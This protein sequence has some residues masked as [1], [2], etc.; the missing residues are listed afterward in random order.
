MC[1]TSLLIDKIIRLTEQFTIPTQ[2]FNNEASSVSHARH[3]GQPRDD[4]ACLYR[5]TSSVSRAIDMAA[6]HGMLL[7]VYILGQHRFHALDRAAHRG[8]K[9]RVL[10]LGQHRYHALDRVTYRGMKLRVYTAGLHRYHT[11]DTAAHLAVVFLLC[12][13]DLS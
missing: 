11:L 4:A 2:E 10:I 9:L 3:C 12:F 13:V 7:L 1:I 6:L 5:G 8:M